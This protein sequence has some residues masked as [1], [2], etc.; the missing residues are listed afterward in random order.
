MQRVYKIRLQ[1]L[2]YMMDKHESITREKLCKA[3]TP[4][5]LGTKVPLASL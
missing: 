4:L 5:K 3:F 1:D 2:A